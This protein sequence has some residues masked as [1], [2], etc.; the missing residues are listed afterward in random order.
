MSNFPTVWRVVTAIAL[1]GAVL[2]Y[3]AG[4]TTGAAEPDGPITLGH[5]TAPVFLGPHE[6]SIT[7]IVF[8]KTFHK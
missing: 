6:H 1:T 3:L 7:A 8:W 4:V 2:A 5:R